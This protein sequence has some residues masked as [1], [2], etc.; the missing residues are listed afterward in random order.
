MV[1]TRANFDEQDEQVESAVPLVTIC[2]KE[3]WKN[4][5]L[6]TL[7]AFLM[8]SFSLELIRLRFP[9]QRGAGEYDI[10]LFVQF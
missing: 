5:A 10:M 7:T 4:M 2:R 9:L 8:S 3:W 1:R 6:L